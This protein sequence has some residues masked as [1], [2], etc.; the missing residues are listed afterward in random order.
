MPRR[1]ITPAQQAVLVVA[2][3]ARFSVNHGEDSDSVKA[4]LVQGRRAAAR[5]FPGAEVREYYDDGISGTTADRPGFQRMLSDVRRGAVQAV[6]A[7]NQSRIERSPEVWELFRSACLFVGIDDLHTWG[8]GLVGLATGRALTGRIISLVNA[9]QAEQTRLNVIDNLA[10]YAAQGKPP[11]GTC[12]GYKRGEVRV[13][14]DGQICS[15]KTLVPVLEQVPLLAQ[16]VDDALDGTPIYRMTERFNDEKIPTARG[17]KIWRP[18]NLRRLL[19]SPTLTAY[20][21][22]VPKQKRLEL[23]AAGIQF[24]T[25]AVAHE[26]GDVYEGLWEPIIEREK[27]LELQ[28]VFDTPGLVYTSKGQ[29]ITRGVRRGPPAKYLFSKFARCGKCGKGLT[30]SR[31]TGE[32]PS[33]LCQKSNGGCGGIGILQEAA[34]KEAVRQFLEELASDEYRNGLQAGDPYA[35]QRAGLANKIDRI[36]AARR[37][38]DDEEMLGEMS[39]EEYKRR[40]VRAVELKAKLV[41]Q[42]NALPPPLDQIDPEALLIAWGEADLDEKRQILAEALDHVMVLPATKMGGQFRPERVKVR[43][44]QLV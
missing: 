42:L 40:G 6:L 21:I 15:I 22:H 29:P 34:D 20:R 25:L 28:R 33:Y 35:D 18:S 13:N 38:D 9:E 5:E 32:K 8:Q 1:R 37:R 2:L 23:K 16:T 43:M 11:G 3:Y 7:K 41:Q 31:R 10:V 17:G 4:Q 12:L 14:L 44:K 24:V 39:R 19:R 36:D 26:Y 27:F 30:G